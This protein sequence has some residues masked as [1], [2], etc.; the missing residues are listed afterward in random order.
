MVQ[1]DRNERTGLVCGGK[2]LPFYSRETRPSLPNKNYATNIIFGGS[3][4]RGQAL[5]AYHG[6]LEDYPH[7]L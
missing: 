4:V 5:H 2:T 7:P 3:E 1:V 6:H